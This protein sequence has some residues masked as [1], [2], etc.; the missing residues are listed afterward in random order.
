MTMLK[1]YFNLEEGYVKKYGKNTIFLI[2]CGS[3]FEV[4][5]CKKNNEFLNDRI[6]IFSRICDMRIANKKSKHAGLS[7]YMSGFPEM[8]L[9]KY[10]KRLTD[11]GYTV[12]V[13]SQEKTC[14]AIRKLSGIYSPGTNFN[15]IT[16]ENN[17][18]TTIWLEIY[19]ETKINKNPTITIGIASVDIVSGDVYTFQSIEKYFNNPTTFD[20]LERYNSSYPSKELCIIHN[21]TDKQLNEIRV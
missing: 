12:V 10:V 13:H 16:E 1:D 19:N 9:E 18:I 17:R 3:F 4:Y 11:S 2:Q 6:V 8:H 21:C 15:C 20:E 7:V 14:P 5:C